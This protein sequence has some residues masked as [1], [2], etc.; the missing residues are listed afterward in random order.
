MRLL[1][2]SV[3]LCIGLAATSL[4]VAAEGTPSHPT[5]PGFGQEAVIYLDVHASTW[6]S[7]GRVSFGIV[8]FLRMKLTSAGFAVTQDPES[9]HDLTLTVDYREER[10][11]PISINLSG[12]EITCLMELEHPRQGRQ[13]YTRI[14]ERPRYAELV[15]APYVDVVEQFQTNP[16]FYFVGDLIRGRID[17]DLDTTGA[18]IQA[19]DRQFY[20]ERH[21]RAATPL[22]TLE[23]PAETFP[24]LDLH[25]ASSARENAVEELGRLKDPRAIDLLKALMFHSE[26]RTRLRAVLALGEFDAPILVPAI[27]RVVQVDSD[28]DVR[29]AAA[30]V[31]ARYSKP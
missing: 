19:L 21:P 14:H 1:L 17:A 12:T 16:Y 8:P 15:T 22:D 31:L 2:I 6:R 20:R 18:L 27:S 26:P 3:L 30:T 10:G 25:F 23:S 4:S 24:D 7:R 28:P 9:P 11:K 5:T 13:L 29:S